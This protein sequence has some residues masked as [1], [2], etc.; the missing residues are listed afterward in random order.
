VEPGR[1][2]F[3]Q[4]PLPTVTE[5]PWNGAAPA[6]TAVAKGDPAA[7]DE[8]GGDEPAEPAGA[9]GPNLMLAIVCWVASATSLF[10]AYNFYAHRLVN[11]YAFVG[12]MALGLGVLFFSLEAL[13]WA[14]PRRPWMAWIFA[15]ATLL[16]L[17]G[18]IY[19]T[20]SHA[21]GRRI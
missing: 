20:L 18:V 17:V 15:P 2:V 12:Y 10:E 6:P 1:F 7:E 16:T 3:T 11:T 5:V 8:S 21:P 19:L 13:L 14:R 4:D 9:A